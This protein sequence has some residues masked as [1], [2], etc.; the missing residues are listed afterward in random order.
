MFGCAAWPSGVLEIASWAKREGLA[1]AAILQVQPGE[2]ATELD[3]GGETEAAL[4]R[5]A[6]RR[7]SQGCDIHPDG[8][9]DEAV[10]DALRAVGGRFLRKM[11]D[12]QPHVVGFRVEGPDFEAVKRYVRAV[13]LFSDAEIVLGGP[14]A[15]SHPIDVLRESGADYLFAGE[16]EE[17]FNQFLR[18]ARERNS[19]DRLPEIPGLAYDYGG[20]AYHN[21]LP[22][23]GYERTVLDTDDWL[24]SRVRRCLRR[25]VRPVAPREV[26][27]A[28]RLDW[29]LLKDFGRSFDGL[30]FTG[31]RG[32]PGECSFCAKLHGPEVRVK[33]APQ[34][35][36]E[37]ESADALVAQG[38]LR[39]TRWKLFQHTDA[40]ALREKDV[41]WAAIYDEDFFLDRRRAVEFFKLW[42]QS[43][44]GDRYRLSVQTNP[45]TLLAAG[46]KF[47]AGLLEWID[48]LKPMVQLGAESFDPEPLARWHKRH[49]VEQLHTV[50]DALEG[51]RQDYTVFI[52]LTD[53]ETTAEELI[54]GLRLLIL[55]AFRRPGMRIA[56]SPLTI[57]LYDSEVRR[58]LEYGRAPAAERVHH[59]SN[60]ERPQP[61]WLDPL[62]ADL[63]DRADA[64][65]HFAL[66]PGH[67]DAALARAFEVVQ[68]RVH[69]E[70]GR[71]CD[72]PAATAARKTRIRHLCDQVD[73]AMEEIREGQF[74]RPR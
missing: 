28:N 6:G 15:T 33:P 41:A 68:S 58:R 9:L 24:C 70:R 20:R 26:I 46:G 17:T 51:T 10:R 71:V 49:R 40:P 2:S 50:L 32:C 64:E 11:I 44:L 62:V 47:H 54:D 65:L 31:G 27:A 42:D 16:A 63:A 3:A 21:T 60:Y 22:A 34:L 12:W 35:L 14:T 30:Y 53:F 4:R 25:A 18:L 1:E 13:R 48:R 43:P 72:E 66:Q 36:E 45:C 57:P 56:G 29:S 5:L 7:L 19:R 61:G 23:D 8:S 73:Q 39:L 55:E 52:L 37:I 38:S 67:R 74:R 69:E 59:F